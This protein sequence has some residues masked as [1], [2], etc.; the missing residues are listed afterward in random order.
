MHHT[1]IDA[2]KHAN[3]QM[4]RRFPT[5]ALSKTLDITSDRDNRV[6]VNNL[7]RPGQDCHVHITI[8]VSFLVGHCVFKVVTSMVDG[9]ENDR[10]N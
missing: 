4:P 3:I 7:V 9:L 1:S 8:D 2:N 5:Q 10:S 6:C